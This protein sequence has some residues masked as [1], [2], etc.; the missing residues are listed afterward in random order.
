MQFADVALHLPLDQTFTY[1]IPQ[2]LR[3]AIVPGV[4]VRVSFQNRVV[5]ATCV[6]THDRAPSF[7]V[8]PLLALVEPKPL[9]TP[10]MLRLA[11]WIARRYGAAIG[12]TLDAALPFAVRSGGQGRSILVVEPLADR[13]A[14]DTAMT[15]LEGKQPK[16]ARALRLLLEAGE[17]LEL[18]ELCAR[19]K[20]GE[21]PIR[22]LAKHELVKLV[23][24]AAK[25]KDMFS[26]PIPHEPD[27]TLTTAQTLV[28]GAVLDAIATGRHRE[29][30]L[31]GVT[32][33]G[34]TEVYLQALSEVVRR[35]QQAIVLVPEIALTPQTVARFRARFRRV[36]VLHSHLTD[37]ERHQQWRAIQRGEADVIIG[38][39]SAVFA[40]TPRLGLVILD[41]EHESTFKQQNSPRYH[42]RD[43]ARTRCRFER[44]VL[45]LG[46]ATP[47]LESY[48]RALSGRSTVLK[49]KERVGGGAF[50]DTIVADLNQVVPGTRVRFL[51]DRLRALMDHVLARG[52]QVIL[53]L[54]RRG[55]ATGAWC[56]ACGVP[57]KC[58]HCD[59][60]LVF[61]RRIGRVLCHYC[62][63]EQRLPETCATCQKPFRLS[64]FGT[65]RVED[66]VRNFFPRARVARMDSDTM[67]ARGAHEAVLTA[68]RE[69]KVDVL[70]GTQ[71]I[72]KG[73]D[74]PDV[75]LVGVVSA[76]TT[77]MIPDYRA[78]ERT[79][80]LLAQVAGRAGRSDK[81]GIVLVQTRNPDHFAVRLALLHDFETF[82][83][84]E[85]DARRKDGYPPFGHLARVVIQGPI[86]A[87]AERAA[88][89][90]RDGLGEWCADD[91]V[92]ILGPA[93]APIAKINEQY[94][95]HVI[96]KSR[97]RSGITR[98]VRVV[99]TWPRPP[100]QVRVLLDVDPWGML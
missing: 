33:S 25:P 30:L 52:E 99:R 40:P 19:A 29:F 65:E 37:A 75:T 83:R 62:G 61:H 10:T 53:F 77:L 91:T 47:A 76:D 11:R 59:I 39:R 93:P 72:A 95:F 63:H 66:E 96:A 42:A 24:T 23:K 54:N 60:A 46:S 15:E 79:F 81:G 70:V 8:K 3:S 41:E 51:S 57:L 22:T 5:G 50:P 9:F 31:F 1:A 43:V 85:L 100:G 36:A 45:L 69:R 87:D 6:T 7:A 92:E 73:L 94:R 97:H 80:S 18:R 67:K 20:T 58:P 71:M 38:A 82:A 4:R 34:K 44:A 35:G 74:F 32:G 84:Y 49:L 90:L 68:F 64:G 21:S 28:L 27:K 17:P 16:Q 13:A 86:E 48:Q 78:A 2:G 26:E 98:F 12:E 88:A 89:Q 56:N 14:L 55:F